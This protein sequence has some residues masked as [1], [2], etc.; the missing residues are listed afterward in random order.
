[1]FLFLLLLLQPTLGQKI[2][3]SIDKNEYIFLV[4]N[5]AA[6]KFIVNNMENILFNDTLMYSVMIYDNLDR[7]ILISNYSK[8]QQFVFNKTT[9][10]LLLELNKSKIS[11]DYVADI[12]ILSDSGD[13]FEFTNLS[14]KFVKNKYLGIY[15]AFDNRF[16][17]ETNIDKNIAKGSKQ[18]N[19]QIYPK[20]FLIMKLKKSV[21]FKEIYI[22]KEIDTMTNGI[23]LKKNHNEENISKENRIF[24]IIYN[25]SKFKEYNNSLI[26]DGYLL[27]NN[28][29]VEVANNS[30]INITYIDNKD[31]N[32]KI[33]VEVDNYDVINIKL[34]MDKKENNPFMMVLS[35]FILICVAAVLFKFFSK[36][37]NSKNI[38]DK[39]RLPSAVLG[40][41]K[42]N[43]IANLREMINAANDFFNKGSRSDIETSY[44]LLGQVL[45]LFISYKNGNIG[46]LTKNDSLLLMKENIH[47]Y[48]KIE[49][50]LEEVERVV[51]AKGKTT[52]SGFNLLLKKTTDFIEK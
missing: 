11:G 15:G 16:V 45:R 42:A 13:I 21:D 9:K 30:F 27:F 41:L 28:S 24:Q 25:D 12:T 44:S 23:V 4:N 47:E 10:S 29:Y 19:D 40:Q 18:I 34:V 31:R 8:S 51:F 17:Y 7:L 2:D 50:L 43:H 20:N 33:V 32:A 6:V 39:N 35:L 37:N 3:L 46:Q 14:I 26:S 36:N 5:R 52:S 48:K 49:D 1:M 22:R 38:T